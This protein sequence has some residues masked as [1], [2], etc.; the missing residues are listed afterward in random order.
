MNQKRK[1]F[2]VML[3]S[4]L[5]LISMSSCGSKAPTDS[6]GFCPKVG[7]TRFAEGLLEICLLRDMKSAWFSNGPEMQALVAAGRSITRIAAS[8]TDAWTTFV[9]EMNLITDSDRTLVWDNLTSTELLA[10]SI[11][12]VGGSDPRWD[13]LQISLGKFQ[14][15]EANWKLAVDNWAQLGIQAI[16]N[17]ESISYEERRKATKTMN[18][19]SNEMESIFD[20]EV[21]PNL[22]PFISSMLRRIG[23]QD[24]TTAVKLTFEYLKNLEK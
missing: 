8:D 18:D 2:A 23:V 22:K 7:E 9:D 16:R 21:A 11:S 12:I 15:A 6:N 10:K 13:G 5:L 24:E 17:K 3:S 14:S 1:L 20:Y 19:A 4:S